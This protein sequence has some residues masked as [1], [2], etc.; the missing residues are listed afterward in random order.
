MASV[1][2][3]KQLQTL[4][5]KLEDERARILRVLQS[6]GTGLGGDGQE[7]EFEELAQRATER[8]HEVEV[9]ERERALLVEV[10]RALVRLDEGSYGRSEKTGEPIRYE[11]LAAVPW[12]RSDVD[13]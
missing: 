2:T 9:A 3:E 5:Q 6:P 7:S 11:R 12:A 4:R 1:L 10:N 13:E 8:T